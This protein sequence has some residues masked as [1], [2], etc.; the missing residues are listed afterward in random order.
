MIPQT[1]KRKSWRWRRCESCRTVSPAG[2]FRVAQS[3]ESGWTTG[4]MLRR[5]PR[6]G[7]RGRTQDFPVVREAHPNKAPS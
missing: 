7:V 3:Y 5:C 1:T 4:R 2:D 6:C